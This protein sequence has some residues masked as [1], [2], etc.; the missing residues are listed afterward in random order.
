MAVLGQ[1]SVPEKGKEPHPG[2]TGIGMSNVAERIQVLYGDAGKITSTVPASGDGTLV[3]LELP[4]LE[5]ELAR[6]AADKIYS[7]RSRTRA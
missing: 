2:Q 4:I 7:E 6:S 1:I 3:T 5:T